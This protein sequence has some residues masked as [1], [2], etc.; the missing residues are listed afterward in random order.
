MEKIYEKKRVL[1]DHLRSLGSAAIAFSAGVDS[2][3]LLKTAHDVLGEK[4]IAVTVRSYLCPSSEF[5]EAEKFCK[6]NGIEQIVIDCQPLTI[7]GFKQNPKNRCYLCKKNI[8]EKITAAASERGI[9]AV[10]EGSNADDVNDYRP[11]LAALAELKIKS[12]LRKAGLTKEEIR[13]LSQEAGLK[14][15]DKPSLACLATRFAYGEEITEE[16]LKNTEL[17]EKQLFSLGI[18]QVRVR[19][20]GSDAR[21]EVLKNDFPKLLSHAEE[22]SKSLHAL[23]FTH[24]SL[25]LDGYRTGSMNVGLPQNVVIL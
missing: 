18:K 8:F 7:E 1:E 16:K 5:E 25:D 21:I 2:T 10:A 11:G 4:A 22:I 19:V 3:F 12:P 17:A 15:W 20:Q 6:E 14:T 23:G 9:N 13:R 24:V